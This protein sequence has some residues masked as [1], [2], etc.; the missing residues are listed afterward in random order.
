MTTRNMP[1]ETLGSSREGCPSGFPRLSVTGRGTGT[2]V[3]RAPNLYPPRS[4]GSHCAGLVEE[5][6]G[7]VDELPC[8]VRLDASHI[9]RPRP[10]L[11]GGGRYAR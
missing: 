3:L 8:P 9:S 6:L 5:S 2:V 7:V 10:S 4:A 1:L 11:R